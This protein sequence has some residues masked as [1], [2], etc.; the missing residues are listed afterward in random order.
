MNNYTTTQ[1][2]LADG[3]VLVDGRLIRSAPSSNSIALSDAQNQAI[4]DLQTQVEELTARP[5]AQAGAT[6]EQLN[7]LETA[8]NEIV[9]LSARP[10]SNSGA[11]QAQIERIA[12]TEQSVSSLSTRTGAVESA[13]ATSVAANVT[14]YTEW[15]VNMPAVGVIQNSQ[16]LALNPSLYTDGEIVLVEYQNGIV[17]Y[18]SDGQV[19]RET[20]R[21]DN[22]KL[23]ISTVS[24]R[25]DALATALDRTGSVYTLDID[26]KG[27]RMTIDQNVIVPKFGVEHKNAS[28]DLINVGTSARTLGGAAGVVLLGAS[29]IDEGA[30]ITATVVLADGADTTVLLSGGRA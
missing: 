28:F 27:H 4:A 18:T 7:R 9:A 8:E 13:Q 23:Q 2:A 21:Q 14:L 16:L 24:D 25:I 29:T 3:Y 19:F 11:T 12:A 15:M 6:D 30:A 26:D 17:H 1:E 22:Y 5:V 20:E 10:V